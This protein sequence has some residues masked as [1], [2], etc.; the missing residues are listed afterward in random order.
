MD[1]KSYWDMQAEDFAGLY[2]K[3]SRL[4]YFL[5][6]ALYLR[7]EQTINE[8][9]Q[10]PDATVLDVGCGPGRNSVDFI[11][12]GGA[13]RVTGVDLAPQMITLAKEHAADCE[14]GNNC[15]FF[16]GDF[17]GRDFADRT[18]D[19]AVALGVMD[20]ILDPKDILEGM[21]R[22]SRSKVIVSFPGRN[23]LRM[24]YRS[25]VYGLKGVKLFWYG[26]QDI[27]RLFERA[28]F[29]ECQ[30]IPCART[31]WLAVA[32]GGAKG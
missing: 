27:E 5:R 18:F 20:Y 17:L 25:M 10:V 6:P 28:G 2:E 4:D 11:R 8:I 24:V 9:K 7:L 13:G 22:L 26:P 23:A 15:E 14:V 31:G 29:N 12:A 21:R 16:E 30:V 32:P 3:P 1:Q 19:F